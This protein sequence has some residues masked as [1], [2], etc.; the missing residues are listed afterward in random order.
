MT[1]KLANPRTIRIRAIKA[2][3][4]SLDIDE[5]A[6]RQLVA[7]LVGK[8]SLKDCTQGELDAILDHLN[9][10]SGYKREDR[11]GVDR[12]LDRSPEARK[13]SALWLLLHR[14]G[15]VRNP[16][17]SA[18]AAYAKRVAGVDDLHWAH[19]KMEPLIEGL[20]A[21]AARELPAAIESR[22]ARLQ[23]V[24]V[25]DARNTVASLVE[26]AAPTLRPDT[27]DALHAAWEHLDEIE[28]PHGAPTR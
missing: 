11:S 22:V 27:F 7:N 9:K 28:A 17:E 8:V 12:R 4:R 24:G 6:H 19:A 3:E 5:S 16:A 21:W 14:L 13:L 23:A 18:L 20:K 26:F 25:L 10:R 2:A 15:A 1:S